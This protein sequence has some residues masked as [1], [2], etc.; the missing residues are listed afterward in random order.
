[1]SLSLSLDRN[2]TPNHSGFDQ[3][4][5]FD[6]HEIT[7]MNPYHRSDKSVSNC[8]VKTESKR[9]K[10]KLKIGA[11]FEISDKNKIMKALN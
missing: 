10:N 6:S 11:T 9:E 2:E 5:C 3:S 8:N 4:Q 7:L 1:M